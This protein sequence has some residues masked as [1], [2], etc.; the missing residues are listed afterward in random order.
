MIESERISFRPF[1]PEDAGAL[2]D[3]LN[4]P[5]LKGVR[6]L[7]W[8][9]PDDRALTRIQVAQIIEKWGDT[10]R[11]AHFAIILKETGAVIGHAAARWGWDAHCPGV[12]L[13]ISPVYQR[14]GYGSEALRLIVQWVFDSIPAHNIGAEVADWNL[15]AQ[16][17]LLKHGFQE[18]GRSRREGM[19]EGKFYDLLLFDILRRE[20]RRSP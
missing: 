5:S 14:L 15:P 7:P 1:E 20:W 11:K 10:D 8:G 17:L 12:E 3:Y 18:A 19:H 6:Y 2:Y 16:K 13:V 9:F 4:H